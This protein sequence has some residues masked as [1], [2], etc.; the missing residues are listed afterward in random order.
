VR[1]CTCI[2]FIRSSVGINPVDGNELMVMNKFK[3]S[4][5]KVG[6]NG[7][8]RRVRHGS[9]SHFPKHV[10]LFIYKRKI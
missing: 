5:E 3:T 10:F 6:F 8:H 1:E 2:F 9:T 7:V 4:I